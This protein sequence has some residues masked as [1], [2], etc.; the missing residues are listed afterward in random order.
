MSVAHSLHPDNIRSVDRVREPLKATK[1][2]PKAASSEVEDISDSAGRGFPLM[3]IP[4]ASL[5]SFSL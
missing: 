2:D 4:A 1:N 3:C 5:R